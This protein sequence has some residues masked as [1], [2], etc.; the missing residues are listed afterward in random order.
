[1]ANDRTTADAQ[2][3]FD[4][5][6]QSLQSGD[7]P[8]AVE[9]F[10][11][12]IRLKPNIAAGYRFRA[13]AYLEL[14]Q[15]ID[16]LNDLDQAI[17]IR[18][19][20][21]MLYADR[22]RV[23]YRQ[24]SFPAAIADCDRALGLDPGLAPLHGLRGECHAANGETQK[25]F[26]D[27]A[28]AMEQDPQNLADYLIARAE[29]HLELED[30]DAA[31]ADA[32][33]AVDRN[34]ESSTV[35]QTRGMIHRALDNESEAEADFTKTLELDPE[36]VLAQL[37]RATVRL[38]L[39]RFPEALA[40]CDTVIAALPTL[41]KAYEIRGMARKFSG[42]SAAALVDYNEAIRLNPGSLLAY[43]LRAGIHYQHQ[44]Y[45]KAIQDHLEALKRDPKSAGT[46]NQ[47]GWIWATAPDP[48]VR[49]GTR[50]KECATRACELTEWQESGYLDTLAAACAELGEYDDAVK[51]M[52]KAIAIAPEHEDDYR[53][54]LE[55]YERE[56]PFRGNSALTPRP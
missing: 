51:W 45:N 39:K 27:F 4:R 35:Y 1:M 42:D 38:S 8:E 24:R 37:A 22:A 5:G 15:R 52:E 56:K 46:F 9:C 12:A 18:S 21:P 23:L 6:H 3:L 34:P 32:D 10:T 41:A 13:L 54:R 2:S 26:A 50:A 43:N 17:R 28:V 47:L 16:A 25:A 53:T 31:L 20:D 36:R 29:L 11:R 49:N 44:Q 7:F 30:Y 40:D 19:D 55:L 48:D 33:L 14:G